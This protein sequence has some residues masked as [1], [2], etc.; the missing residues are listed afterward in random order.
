MPYEWQTQAFVSHDF[1]LT[2]KYLCTPDMR[3]PAC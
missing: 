1:E 2:P 3:S